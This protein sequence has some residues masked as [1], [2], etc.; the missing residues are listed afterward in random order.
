MSLELAFEEPLVRGLGLVHVAV[1]LGGLP[2]GAAAGAA[3][4]LAS[5]LFA[6][7]GAPSK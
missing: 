7:I 1:H 3:A 6:A 2:N 5:V 4:I